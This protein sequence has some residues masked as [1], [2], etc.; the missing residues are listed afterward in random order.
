M[1]IKDLFNNYKS[2]QFKPAQSELSASKLVESNEFIENKFIDKFDYIPPIDFTTASNFAKF[3]SAE[4]Y[5]EYAFKR[6]YQQ[7]PYDGSLAEKQE[8]YNNSTFLDRYIFDH[9]Y[10]RTTGHIIFSSDGWGTLGTMNDGYGI[11][12]DLQYISVL[13]GP[14]TASG[15]MIGKELTNTFDNSMIYDTSKSRAGS[16]EWNPTSGST[17]E[18]WMK[19]DQ[20]ITGST[21]KE[22]I[23]DIWNGEASSSTSYGRIRLE[24]TGASD[25]VGPLRLT[26]ISGSTG[27]QLRDI[28]P[29]TL[30]TSSVADGQWHHYA[31]SF[32]SS[33]DTTIKLYRDGT[34]LNTTTVSAT[35]IGDIKNVS[36]G[37]NAYIGALQTKPSGSGG[38]PFSGK[39]SASLDEFRYWKK[40]RTTNEIGEFWFTNLGG[41]TNKREY[42][43]DLGVYFKFNEGITADATIDNSILDY[44]GRI[45]NGTFVGY[46]SSARSTDSAMESIANVEEEKDPIIYSSHP[47][48]SSSLATYKT[49][50]SIQDYESTSLLYNLFP[51]WIVEQD[52]ENGKNLKYLT[53]IMASYFDTLNAQISGLTE[54]K[55][56][57]YFSGSI[58][59]NTYSREVL[60]GQ[61]FVIPDMFIEADLLEEIRGKDDNETYDEDIQ[62][63]KNLIYNN[64]YNN[65]NYIYKSKG[66]EKSFRNFF[67]CFG[68][69]SELIKLNLYSDGSTY[70]Y[71][72]NY[73]FT[74]IAKPVLN[75]NK[76]SQLDGTVYLSSSSGITY[77]SGSEG[78]DEEY[79]SITL[80]CEA[81]FP[82]K[83][84]QFET[85]YFPTPFV[86]ASIVGFHRAIASA[87]D[88]TWHD[89]D[90]YLKI[91]S[92]KQDY[93]SRHAK[94]LLTGSGIFLTSS[95]YQDVYDNNKWILA[96]RVKHSKYPFAGEVTGSSIGG[97][98][99]VEFYG[100]NSVAN[101]VKNE[102][103]K[104]D[105]YGMIALGMD[106][107]FIIEKYN[108]V[109]KY[110]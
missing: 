33:T 34:Y 26:M 92:I 76:E 24:L 88:F 84:D 102:L 55:S 27:F 49:T 60:R 81:I 14:H 18:F 67:R 71:K 47:T 15:G 12:S 51:S 77:L 80:E 93:D 9:V 10:P 46:T 74:S 5:Y 90:T 105:K 19:K 108:E 75:L 87:D 2:D 23:L 22:V 42:N 16:F 97:D 7:Y 65:L 52:T 107:T 109:E 44:S 96:A 32:I 101:N 57:R 79:T 73:E 37:V 68:A 70:L 1:S 104:Y 20:F 103:K 45:S 99:K 69:D 28:C 4:L 85:G 6:I 53:Q 36:S 17:I 59:P 50:G 56:K 8:F 41:G 95:Q 40:Q 29:S 25:G 82:R 78:N 94:F 38:R 100:V 54:F 21:E 11:S 62:K 13:G 91:Y 86:S 39:L 31:V 89:E 61:G 72:D 30:T 64:I 66:T 43:T 110:A 35:N 63:I 98:Y 58:K 83:F 48:V 3:G 106:T